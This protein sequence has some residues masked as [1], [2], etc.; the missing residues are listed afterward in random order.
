MLAVIIGVEN[1]ND[2]VV[3]YCKIGIYHFIYF[4]LHS[5]CAGGPARVRRI[6]EVTRKRLKILKIKTSYIFRLCRKIGGIAL[7]P[8]FH[9]TLEKL[10]LNSFHY[11][12]AF[13]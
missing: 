6:A 12:P 9:H 4:L 1:K 8:L 3:Y 13:P 11:L 7:A 10:H 5:R 2:A